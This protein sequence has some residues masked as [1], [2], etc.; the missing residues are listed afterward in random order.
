MCTFV[1]KCYSKSSLLYFNYIVALL[2]LILYVQGQ[3]PDM[4]KSH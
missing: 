4:I 3:I 2:Q 1:K